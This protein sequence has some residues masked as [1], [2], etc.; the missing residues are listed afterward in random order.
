[1]KKCP[2]CAEEIQDEAI[3]CRHCGADLAEK[4]EEKDKLKSNE[5]ALA[6]CCHLSAFLGLIVPFGNIL[7]PLVVWLLAKEEY[8]LVDDQG[9]EALNFQIS[10]FL[11]SLVG[12]A[13]VFLIVGI[14]FLVVLTLFAL[15]QV[16]KASISANN[17]VKYRYPLSIRFIK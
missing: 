7:G 1:M 3:K 9:R 17:G 14:F 6:M 8:P 16:I 11:Y 13:L 2:Y 4:G 15:I 10:L 12:F 5:R